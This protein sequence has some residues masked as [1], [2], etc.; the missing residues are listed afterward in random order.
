MCPS[1]LSRKRRQRA[2]GWVGGV[3]VALASLSAGAQTYRFNN[4]E[5][6]VAIGDVHGAYPEFTQVLKGTGLVDANL[7]WVGGRT[8]LVQ[9]GD[10]FSRGDQALKVIELLMRLQEEAAAAGGAVHPL[11]GNHEVMSLTGD[12]RYVSPG[13]FAT[14]ATA[15]G[16]PRDRAIGANPGYLER[17]Q[18]LAPD[19]RI[20]RWLLQ[21][22]VMV[23]INDNLFVHGGLSD[24]LA[25]QTLEQ[26]NASALRDVR[27]FAEGWHALVNGGALKPTD[28]FDRILAVANALAAVPASTAAP[29]ASSAATA[30]PATPALVSPLQA[31]AQAILAAVKGLPFQSNGPV[32]YRG[33]SVCHP[34]TESEVVKAALRSLGANRVVVGHTPTLDHHVSLRLDNQ[35]ARIDT[36]MNKVAY[37]GIPAALVIERGRTQAFHLGEGLA[38]PR[39]EANREWVRPYGMTDAQ[40]EDFLLKAAVTKD[41]TLDLGVTKPRRLTLERDGKRIRAV[42]KA[43]DSDPEIRPSGR[44]ERRY[45]KADRFQYEIAAYKLDRILGLQMVPV[46]VERNV[47]GERGL[48]QYWVEGAHN[49]TDRV[50]QK[51]QYDSDCS[52]TRQH[53]LINAFDVLIHNLDRNT[54]N[55]LYDR[56]WQVWMID[57]TRAFSTEAGRPPELRKV[58]IVVSPQMRAALANVTESQLAPLAPYLHVRQIRALVTR[59]QA[60]RNKP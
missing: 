9:N 34:Y 47:G 50:Q 41:E 28:D 22:P 6:V 24:K 15:D 11:L 17:M 49:E 40:L 44:W 51:L 2:A 54:G 52:F 42:F 39:A 13:E 38:P 7:H 10:V 23:A 26:V 12:L 56:D 31:P 18:A 19:G 27:A 53:Q 3:L 29:A 36:G 14:Y 43:F 8:H 35:V 1:N 37:E 20:G 57:H 60:L 45:D 59:A 46:A 25:G 55:I 5:R 30:A 16:T 4:V 33:S 32:W 48:V 58:P 21:R